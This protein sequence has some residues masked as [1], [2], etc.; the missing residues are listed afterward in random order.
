MSDGIEAI[1]EHE[2]LQLRL[3]RLSIFREYNQITDPTEKITPEDV[4]AFLARFSK[5][6]IIPKHMDIDDFT[7]MN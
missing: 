1:E 5:E 2:A 7:I 6:P 3:K 4:E